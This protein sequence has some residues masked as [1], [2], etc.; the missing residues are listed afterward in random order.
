MKF[1]SRSSL[2]TAAVLLIA[3]FLPFVSYAPNRVAEA[4][5]LMVWSSAGPAGIAVLAA[6]LLFILLTGFPAARRLERFVPGAVV[7]AAL[8]AMSLSDGIIPPEQAAAARIGGG[9]GFWIWVLSAYLY[10]VTSSGSS[11]SLILPVLLA[12]LFLAGG[13]LE[14]LGPVR[15][16]AVKRERFLSETAAHLSLATGATLIASLMAIPSGIIAYRSRLF[17]RFAFTGANIVQ[18]LPSL[19]LFG[20]MIAPLAWLSMRFPLLRSM[21]VKG[22]GNFPALL[23]LSGYAA[24]PILRNTFTGLEAIPRG[25]IQAG[26]GMGMSPF[27]LLA[28]VEIPLALPVILA[29]LRIAFVQAI[30][31]TTVAALIGAG[32]LG[33]FVFQGLGQAAPD[34][35]LL[36]VVPLIALAV[37]A[38]GGLKL[39]ERLIT[40]KPFR[41]NV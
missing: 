37:A 24:L 8:I 3:A 32:G 36:G 9:P 21:G 31:N 18:T 6:A 1:S 15:E 19:A 30:G 26:R 34:L 11:R 29:G 12:A 20:L 17:S 27:N 7:L 23:A 41:E 28:M 33:N 5:P 2:V 4:Q 16:F 10:G 22:V 39:L 14:Y 25:A 40:P 38:D 35:I 13:Q